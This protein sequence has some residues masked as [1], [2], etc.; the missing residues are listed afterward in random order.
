MA[1]ELVCDIVSAGTSTVT[2]KVHNGSEVPVWQ[3]LPGA[4]E[5]S[6]ALIRLLPVSGFDTVAV[7]VTVT[8]PPTGMSPV[9]V[10]DA[11]VRTR[12]PEVATWSP[13]GVESSAMSARGVVTVMLL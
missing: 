8:V 5:L 1:T 7:R 11:P 13:V 10:S 2:R 12:V 9:Q 6:V 3:L 4:V